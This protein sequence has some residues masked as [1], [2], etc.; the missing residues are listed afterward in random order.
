MGMT[1]ADNA[2]LIRSGYEAFS[3]G[4]LETVQK[5]FAPDIKWHVGGRSQLAGDYVGWDEVSAFFGKLVDLSGGTF[6]IEIHDIL[7]SDDHVIVLAKEQATRG[8]N[9]L[10]VNSG[11]V[12]H[13]AGGRATEFWGLSEDAYTED[14]FWG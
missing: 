3:K 2:E 5:V 9:R 1:A 8:D 11:H 12:W 4:D 14:A 13:V 10:D 6:N 7:A